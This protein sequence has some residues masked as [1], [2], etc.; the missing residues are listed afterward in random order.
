[1]AKTEF[2]AFGADLFDPHT[3]VEQRDDGPLIITGL[4]ARY[5]HWYDVAGMFQERI[6]PGAITKTLKR[7]P[8]IRAM[9]NHDPNFLLGR[10]VSDSLTVTESRK[11]IKY[12]IEANAADPQAVSVAEKVRRGDVDGASIMF[13]TLVDEWDEKGDMPKRSIKEIELVE[14]G[15][16][17]FP[18]NDGA[19]ASLRSTL[20]E[21][22]EDL[23]IDLVRRALVKHR[24]QSELAAEERAAIEALSE[25]LQQMTQGPP[26]LDAGHPDGDAL[27]D[28]RARAQAFALRSTLL[29]GRAQ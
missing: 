22:D 7:K 8:D 20:P 18:A 13:R 4:G 12:E 1:M 2:R 15:P 21:F 3:A 5:N 11:G 9:F 29:A 24:F 27:P 28:A 6:L 25:R 23:D 26:A 17:V 19:T 14:V 10:T 16:V